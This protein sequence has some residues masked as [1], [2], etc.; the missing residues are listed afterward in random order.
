MVVL[1]DGSCPF[2]CS[3][4]DV[5]RSFLKPGEIVSF[6]SFDR[7]DAHPYIKSYGISSFKSVICINDG[8]LFYKSDAVFCVIGILR[9]PYNFLYV[10]NILPRFFLDSCYDFIARRRLFL[11]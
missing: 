8:S 10:F 11:K 6:Y 5:L 2:C 4:V 9:S 1:Y 7:L 3:V